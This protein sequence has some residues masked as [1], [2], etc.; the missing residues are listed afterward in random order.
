MRVSRI[1]PHLRP[2]LWE[3]RKDKG[4]SASSREGQEEEEKEEIQEGFD[5]LMSIL[6]IRHSSYLL[7]GLRD[8]AVPCCSPSSAGVLL[9]QSRSQF[10]TIRICEE[11]MPWVGVKIVCP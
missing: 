3:A 9:Q 8:A 6:I 5:A 7:F 4:K 1:K 10:T 2:A 11:K